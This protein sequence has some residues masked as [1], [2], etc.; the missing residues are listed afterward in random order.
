[1]AGLTLDI[2]ANTREVVRGIKNVS[3]VLE[4][5]G[6]SLD[7]LARGGDQ[8]GGK[9]EDSF[10]GTIQASEKVEQS[11]KDLSRT[12]DRETKDAADS[13][14]KVE[15]SFKDLAQTAQRESRD[16]GNDLSRNVKDGSDAAKRG[17]EEIGDESASTAKEMAASF[18][19]SAQSIGDAFQEVAA[20]AFAGF[21]PAGLIAGTAA[22]IGIGAVTAELQRQQEELDKLK[23]RLGG[24]YQ[25][26]IE[27]G[28]TFISDQQ[29]QA[30][31]MDLIWNPDR[32]QE[33]KDTSEA[34]NALG[35]DHVDI[36]RARNGDEEALNRIVGR[37][38]DLYKDVARQL[39]DN[40]RTN[41]AAA[42]KRLAELG[43]IN[44]EYI[45]LNQIQD[46]NAAKAQYSANLTARQAERQRDVTAA[47]RGTGGEIDV[48]NRKLESLP[49][50]VSAQ[51]NVNAPG[52]SSVE[53]RIRNL[54]QTRIVNVLINEQ[55]NVRGG[56]GRP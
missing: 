39:S 47:T 14:E 52:L 23:E 10:K 20:N 15:R 25:E 7:D 13:V 8:A 11:Y 5:V 30:G 42:S 38:K 50:N 28:R 35:V 32:A 41:D 34:A 27:D 40:D 3:D 54:Q 31:M 19:G 21:G 55:K 12:A 56:M 1:V 2:G 33:Y 9:L 6:D 45:D 44:D 37:S 43:R 17:V 49:R 51:I 53:Q 22:A 24:M 48:L 26:A 16:I 46:E 4:D 29:I 36:M 18:D